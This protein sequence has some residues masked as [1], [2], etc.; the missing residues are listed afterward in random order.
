MTRRK[1]ATIIVELRQWGA[2]E[3]IYCK[4]YDTMIRWGRIAAVVGWSLYGIGMVVWIIGYYI[5]GHPSF[6]RWPSISPAW[7]AMFLQNLE[8]E[9]GLLLTTVGT[10]AIY[11]PKLIPRVSMPRP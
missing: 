3:R 4:G 6:L 1:F 8:C 9:L 7:I 2:A 10:I 11:G 5:P